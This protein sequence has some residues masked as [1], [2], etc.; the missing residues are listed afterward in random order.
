MRLYSI[1]AGRSQKTPCVLQKMLLP[2]SYSANE[3]D[4]HLSWQLYHILCCVGVDHLPPQLENLLHITMASQ[5]EE[6]G[7]WCSAAFVLQHVSTMPQRNRALAALVGRHLTPTSRD[8]TWQLL[9]GTTTV[10][11]YL[12]HELA[13]PRAWLYQAVGYCALAQG[14]DAAA[15]DALLE[16]NELVAAH[17]IIMRE[18]AGD[19]ILTGRLHH[20]QSLLERLE[21]GMKQYNVSIPGF[22]RQGHLLLNALQLHGSSLSATKQKQVYN[23]LVDNLGSLVAETPKDRC[24]ALKS[25][26]SSTSA[27]LVCV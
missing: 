17:T 18:L 4:V 9:Q 8:A 24:V 21:Q 5:L 11:D 2:S 16:A 7:A 15:V 25:G 3:H 6:Q 26:L 22:D 10:Q 14:D 20:L 19:Y 27:Q 23:M 12:Q 1:N 13:L